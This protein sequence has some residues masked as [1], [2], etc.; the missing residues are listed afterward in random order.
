[1]SRIYRNPRQPT[2]DLPPI[3]L[4]TLLFDSEYGLAQDDTILHQ[5]AANPSNTITK[6]QLRDLTQ[7]IS[8]GLRRYYGIGSSGPN[9]DV[10]TVISHGQILVPAMFF[11]VIGVGGVYS[12]ASPSSTT[13]EL[14]RQVRVGNSNLLVCG[15]EHHDV[16]CKAAKECG[17]PLSRVLFLESS[18]QWRLYSVDGTINAITTERLGWPR[19]TDPK[20]LK[21]SLI[22]ILWSSGTT[23]LPKGVMLSHNNLVAETYVTALSGRQWAEAELARGN[24]LPPFELRTLAHLP[25]SHIA[26][27]FG[28][29]IAPFFSGGSVVWMRKY[30]WNDMLKYLKQYT[31]TSFYTVPSIYLRISKAPEVTDHFQHV[32][33][34]TTGAAPTDGKLQTAANSKLGNGVETMIGQTWGL[35]ETTG[36]VTMMPKGQSDVSG[37]VTP[38]LPTVELR[39][40]DDDFRDVE[41]GQEGELLIRSPLVT[42]GYYNNP[43]ATRDAFRDDWFC[44]GD[45]GVMRDGKLFIV[46]RKKE[47]L[48]YKGLQ[49]APAELENALFTHPQIE[50][51]AVVGIPAPDDPGTD[52]PRAYIVPTRP[53]AISEDEAKAWVAD[54]LAPY[55]QLRGGVCFVDEIPKNAVGKFLR[56]EL[57]ERAKREVGLKARL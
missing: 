38:I 7:R 27:L 53:G 55:K 45:I 44:S 13:A 15:A 24:E 34:A 29:L 20:L 50:E 49:V 22:T 57:R 56:R 28:Y 9:K 25:I 5:E 1:M 41:P 12:A 4:L 11:G 2:V 33:V 54:R 14:A 6:R 42:N 26:G 36:A 10:V 8:H 43:Q 39:I 31:I 32:G 52:W 35:S 19:I 30:N 16:A 48:K 47:L 46:D 51:A 3:D 23:G 21:D 40:V 17:L 37:S 18:P